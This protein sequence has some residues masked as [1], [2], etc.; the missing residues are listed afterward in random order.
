[1]KFTLL[2]PC[3]RYR[4]R[5]TYRFGIDIPVQT[6]V[7][8]SLYI[9]HFFG[10]IVNGRSIFRANCTLSQGVTL[11][12][13]D[14]GFPVLGNHVYV[15]PGAKILGPVVLG[16]HAVVGANGEVLE[17]VPPLRRHRWRAW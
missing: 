10:I 6:R 7:G 17:D 8:P 2:L 15:A 9:G 4:R 5:L 16:D 3:L 14:D 13:K 1:M 11:G 12:K